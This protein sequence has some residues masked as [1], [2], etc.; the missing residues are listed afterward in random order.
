MALSPPAIDVLYNREQFRLAISVKLQPMQNH[1]AVV[2]RLALTG[3]E[4]K[5]RMLSIGGVG[6]SLCRL[7]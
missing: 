6:A 7:R 3:D 1:V 2:V 5:M 4:T